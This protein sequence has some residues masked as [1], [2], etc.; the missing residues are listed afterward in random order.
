MSLGLSP[1]FNI[2][3]QSPHDLA[4]PESPRAEAEEG[5]VRWAP[6]RYTVR[7]TTADGRLVLWNTYSGEMRVIQPELRSAAEA[8]LT[9][10]G[11][12]ARPLG[13]VK[14]LS[15]RGFLVREGTN[16][17]RRV[18]VGFGQQQ[19]RGDR[20]ELILLAS[21]DCNFRCQYCYEDFL[22]GTMQPW[23][24]T[25]VK[26][27]VEK[28]LPRLRSFSVSWFGGEP[29]YG[30][31][32]IEDL[33]PF[34][35]EVAEKH[36][37]TFSSSMTTNGYLLSPETTEKLLSWRIRRFQVTLD[38]A[39]ED[40]D[41]NRPARD[42][43]GTFWTI[44]ENLRALHE[45]A[46]EFRVD[47]RVNFD[48]QNHSRVH[49]LLSIIEKELDGDRRFQLLFR[50][51]GQWGG[52]NDEHLSVCGADEASQIAF[53]LKQE[54]RRRSLD[55]TDDIR[56]VKGL[57]AQVCY[58]ARPYNFI[59]GA[60]GKLMKCTIDLDKHDRNVVGRLTEEGE[61]D[62]DLDKLARWTEPA[63][64]SD[65]KCQKCVVLP[66]CQGVYCPQIRIESGESPCTPLRRS[67]KRELRGVAALSAEEPSAPAGITT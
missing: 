28:R 40:H 7:A 26:R 65:G 3:Q 29:L 17:Y 54:A 30:L 31:A 24:R 19:Y 1:K 41:R 55:I 50:A 62:I 49:E 2:L 43:Q 13:L 51:V 37:L 36:S 42:G 32:A 27:L 38:G 5:S 57:G 47:V 6:S 18:Q 14:Y 33:A 35:A 45:S 11:F 8:L 20:L 15:D 64:E 61:L 66:V 22:R 58:A 67:Y 9:K 56:N 4:E 25:G 12:A 10:K 34:F 39:P 23:V 16:E 21:E 48:Q 52:P 63:F 60:S 53:D 44:L 59:I 46:Q